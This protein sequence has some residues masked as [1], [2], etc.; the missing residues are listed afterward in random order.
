MYEKAAAHLKLNEKKVEIFYYK[1][2][3][4]TKMSIFLI[5]V[6]YSIGSLRTMRPENKIRDILTGK[7]KVKLSLFTEDDLIYRKM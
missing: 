7:E 6:Q 3:N 1:I 4:K 5:L 2:R